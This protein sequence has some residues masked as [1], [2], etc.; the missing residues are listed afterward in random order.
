MLS[1]SKCYLDLMVQETGIQSQVESY[2]KLKKRYLIYPC[3]TLSIIRY[4]SRVKWSNPRKGVRLFA[5]PRRSR[6]WKGIFRVALDYGHQIYLL[7][8]HLFE[9]NRLLFYYF[10]LLINS[11]SYH[12]NFSDI[13]S[14]LFYDN[15]PFFVSFRQP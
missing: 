2:Q 15:I 5:T 3:L 6:Y 7:F 8:F 13:T 10:F 12:N 11:L 1:Q 14:I 9:Y 4:V